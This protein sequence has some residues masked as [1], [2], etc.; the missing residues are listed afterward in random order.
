MNQKHDVPEIGSV[1][2]LFTY[3]SY[4]VLILL[5]HFRDF[6]GRISGWT[7]YKEEIPKKGF[8]VLLKS[9]E[10]FYTRR[11]YGRINDCWNRPIKSSPSASIDVME[12]VSSNGNYSYQFTGKTT[13][14]LNTGSYNYLGFADDWRN[15]CGKSVL[16]TLE[17]W[18]I[19]M[20]S[21]RLDFGSTA[22]H[23]ELE[24][25][26]AKF[27]N[28]EAAMVYGMGFA[29]NSTTVPQLMG[30]ECLIV[31]D[32]LNHTS[33][34]SGARGSCA[35]IRV[36][37]HNDPTHL[38]SILRDA[39]AS[40]QPRHHR[41]WKK[42]MVIVEGIYS[43]EG[44]VSR[45]PEILKIS[46]KY[47]AYLYVDEAHSIGALGTSGRGVCEFTGVDHRD[48][49]VLMGTFTK[50]FGGMG[51]YIAGSKQLI[52]HLRAATA[53]QLYHCAMS[54]IVCQ[55]VITAFRI[56][57]G[58]DGTTLG[59]LKLKSLYDNSVYF[60]HRL[61]DMGLHVYGE[62]GSP[63]I[64]IM[65]YLPCKLAAFSRECLKRGLAV[66]VVG[67]PAT[68]VVLSRVRFCISAAHTRADLDRALAI[69]DEVTDIL[70]MKYNRNYIG[71]GA[72]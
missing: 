57:T 12:R 28:K 44:T 7:R 37:N 6:L 31:S 20:C 50:S 24:D 59:Q 13:H 8:S 18:P 66:V 69:I 27:L 22:L 36:F 51:G 68:S 2:A 58:E 25:I 14:C 52:D 42:I 10:S 46:K 67:F 41:P 40:G 5:G 11:L 17:K 65:I 53:G 26:V 35:I 16:S 33:I 34:V 38:E 70:L 54:P 39:I 47:K 29:T 72:Y 23:E 56:I 49:D 71:M 15:S 30:P 62:D 43:M 61:I 3:Y 45:L 64:P 21:A 32:S 4:A 60:R 1:I 63:I 48:I 19:S 55:Q 9:W